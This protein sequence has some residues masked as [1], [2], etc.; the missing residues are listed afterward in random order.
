MNNI[1]NNFKND[2]SVF[3]AAAFAAAVFSLAGCQLTHRGISRIP[4]NLMGTWKTQ[5]PAWQITLNQDGNIESV[6]IPMGQIII[7]PNQTNTMQM[8]DGQ[9]SIFETGDFE[10]SFDP[11]SNELFAKILIS[12]L[13]IKIGDDYIEGSREDVFVGPLAEDGKQWNATWF[14]IFDYGPRFPMDPDAAGVPV[15]FKKVN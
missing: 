13:N 1:L 12:H 6:L 7:K 15:I 3:L 11:I 10:T 9:I 4:S 2:C 14:Q 5:D 8:I